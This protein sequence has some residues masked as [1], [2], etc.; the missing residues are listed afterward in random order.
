MIEIAAVEAFPL[1]YRETNDHDSIRH[2][3]LVRVEA[4][5]GVV[6]WGE[7][8]TI[9]RAAARATA[10][11]VADYAPALRGGGATPD[12]AERILA[13]VG[14][15]HGGAGID[16]FA[17]SGIDMALWDIAARREGVP[18]AALLGAAPDAQL[19]AVLTAHASDSELDRMS[20]TLAAQMRARGAVGVK[21]AFGKTGESR[22]GVDVDRDI[23]FVA[24]LRRAVGPDALIM[25]DVA[26]TLGWTLDDVLARLPHMAEH[27]LNWLEEP[28]GARDDE[29]YA[30][31]AERA[32]GVRIATGEREWNVQGVRDVLAAGGIDVIG[33]DP[34]RV[35]GVSGFRDAAEACARAGV[36]ANAHAFAGP[37]IHAS[38]LA[39][40]AAVGACTLF[41]VAPARNELYELLG[42]PEC[43]DSV[44][45]VRPFAGPG[46]GFEV[47]E[48]RVRAAA[49]A[50]V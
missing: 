3:T 31:L 49:T 28:L 40:S 22:L 11:L 5:D 7:A 24:A 6:G 42:A 23:A 45:P 25:V 18:L 46:L 43:H 4:E 17:V 13:R 2:S 36:Q 26:P 9:T 21:I 38:S 35:R 10:L 37:L 1:P 39:L 41:E 19:D 47:D 14:W 44:G 16:S 12:A 32:H 33:L 20:E 27:G 30:A 15:W 29:G 34:G 50:A 8:A 48:D